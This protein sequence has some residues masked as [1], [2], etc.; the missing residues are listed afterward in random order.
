MDDVMEMVW[1]G[2]TQDLLGHVLHSYWTF[3][4]PMTPL[5]PFPGT[6][7]GTAANQGAALNLLVFSVA[8]R[9]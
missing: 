1:D 9:D 6:A 2:V 8:R 5:G 7:L 3:K 4:R